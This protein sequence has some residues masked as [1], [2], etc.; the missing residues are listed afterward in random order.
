MENLLSQVLV[1]ILPHTLVAF[2]FS[3]SSTGLRGPFSMGDS[4]SP[5]STPLTG[6][7]Y[8]PFSSPNR[9]KDIPETG[10]K[11]NLGS[12]EVGLYVQ[13]LEP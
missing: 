1:L 4:G 8:L 10:C 3:S 13:A 7:W 2:P 11:R 5:A 9:C 6:I 12:P